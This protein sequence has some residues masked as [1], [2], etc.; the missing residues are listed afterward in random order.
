MSPWLVIVGAGLGAFVLTQWIR[1]F[2]RAVFGKIPRAV[3]P[4]IALLATIGLV[5]VGLSDKYPPWDEVVLLVA[6]ADGL[7]WVTYEVVY[8]L[9]ATKDRRRQEVMLASPRRR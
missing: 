9:Q 4:L 3:K 5:L 2:C 1:A 8:C 6:A 7:A